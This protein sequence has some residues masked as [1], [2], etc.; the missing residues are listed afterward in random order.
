MAAVLR[1]P[2]GAQSE[3]HHIKED[4]TDA[5]PLA[6]FRGVHS[7]SDLV[8]TAADAVVS[9]GAMAP[10]RAGGLRRTS[11]GSHGQGSNGRLCDGMAHLQVGA[12]WCDIVN[13]KLPFPCR[14]NQRL[15]LLTCLHSCAQEQENKMLLTSD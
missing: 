4:M 12:R 14:R 7:E 3:T 13:T 10:A 11:V 5:P 9:C 8:R 1:H 6:Y 15:C 2:H